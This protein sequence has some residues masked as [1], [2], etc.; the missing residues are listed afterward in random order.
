[1]SNQPVFAG[2]FGWGSVSPPL[3][4]PSSLSSP[5]AGIFGDT[6]DLSPLGTRYRMTCH[7]G[8]LMSKMWRGANPLSQVFGRGFRQGCY[9]PALRLFAG[10][11]RGRGSFDEKR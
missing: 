7:V 1:L 3:A 10:R 8:Q 11:A 2:T 9:L 5:P 6:L 4:L